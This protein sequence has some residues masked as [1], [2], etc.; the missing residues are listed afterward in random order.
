MG[1]M[2]DLFGSTP[3]TT[4]QPAASGGGDLMDLLGGMGLDS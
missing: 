4:A 3:S 2:M 1:D